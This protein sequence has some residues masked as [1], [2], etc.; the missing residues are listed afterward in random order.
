MLDD[1]RKG[2]VRVKRDYDLIIVGGGAAGLA[3]AHAAAHV[4][5]KVAIIEQA[6]LGGSALWAGCVPRMALSKAGELAAVSTRLKM[7]GMQISGTIIDTSGVMKVVKERVQAVAQTHTPQQLDILGITVIQGTAR[8]INNHMITVDGTQLSAK[9]FVIATG[10]SLSVPVIEGLQTVPYVTCHTF[11]KREQIPA[12][13]IILGAD[14]CGIEFARALHGLGVQVTIIEPGSRILAHEDAELA[15]LVHKELTRDGIV[16][17][18]GTRAI[19]VAP[20]GSGVQVI[21]TPAADKDASMT[22]MVRAELLFVA[23][24]KIPQTD[25]LGLETLGMSF[26]EPGICVNRQLRTT[27]SNI[28]ACGGVIGAPGYLVRQQGMIAGRNACVSWWKRQKFDAYNAVR[29]TLV[30]QELVAMGLN[31]L[32]AHKKYDHGVTVYKIKYVDS[33]RGMIEQSHG[34]AKFICDARG[35]LLGA[36]I[37]GERASELMHHILVSQQL[38]IPFS[39]LAVELYTCASYSDI[40]GMVAKQLKK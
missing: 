7:F 38:G 10:S 39:K 13:I 22:F 30:G 6:A 20:A 17:K 24:H 11:W 2:Y 27:V 8:F 12:S 34:L 18:P 32:Q 3:A 36:H 19:K 14:S 9:K 37:L 15:E 35:R 1:I 29:M 40:V 4:G 23:A 16:I 25:G 33:E 26:G 28:Y 31:E 5:R 21:C